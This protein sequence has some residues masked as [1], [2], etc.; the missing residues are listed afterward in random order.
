[1]EESL[2]KI[3]NFLSQYENIKVTNESDNYPFYTKSK[4][5]LSI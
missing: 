3:S 1:M 2:E 5:A 4:P